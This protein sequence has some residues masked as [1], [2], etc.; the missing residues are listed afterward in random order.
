VRA[1]VT[2]CK[3][4]SRTVSPSQMSTYQK[5]CGNRSVR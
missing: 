3:E 4:P 5:R 1:C 2:A